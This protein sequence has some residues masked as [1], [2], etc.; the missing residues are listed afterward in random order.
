L[1]LVNSIISAPVRDDKS[2][3]TI[4]EVCDFG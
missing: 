2:V 1:W 3:E 4:G